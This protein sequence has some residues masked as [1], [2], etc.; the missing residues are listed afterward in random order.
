MSAIARSAFVVAVAALA[1]ACSGSSNDNS[2]TAGAAGSVSATSTGGSVS[3]G[4]AAGSWSSGGA[5]GSAAT[6]TVT[7]LTKDGITW[8]FS[9]PVVA[10]QFITGDYFVVGPVTISA[11]NPAPTTA[12]PYLN[13]S[14]VNLPTSNGKSGFDSR[15]T[16]GTDESWWFDATLRSYPPVALQAGDTLVSSLSLATP[17]GGT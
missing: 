17:Q 4:G 7:S 14:V 6:T 13:G 10:G 16:D 8:T 1:W 2:S 12:D 5:A 3:N 11:I 15:L 9:A